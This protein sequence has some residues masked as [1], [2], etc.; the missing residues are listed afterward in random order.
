MLIQK[1]CYKAVILQTLSQI[2]KYYYII[3]E[4]T[5]KE[6]YNN[7]TA[8]F[9]NKSKQK[10]T[11]FSKQI[12]EV[13]GNSIQRQINWDIASRARPYNGCT[14]KCDLCLTEKLMIAKTD[15][16]S[17]LNTRDEFISKYRHMNKFILKCFKTVNDNYVALV[18]SSYSKS[19]VKLWSDM[20][21]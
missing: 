20:T 13:K 16:S 2:N 15:P 19:K 14:R 3:C 4:K 12:W 7:H 1:S 8:T 11:Q 9:R 10:S 6:R 17:L 21:C 5:F 18:K